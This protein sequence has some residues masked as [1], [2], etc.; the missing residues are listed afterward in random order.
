ML[1]ARPAC[2]TCPLSNKVGEERKDKGVHISE[3]PFSRGKH[4]NL[5][6]VQYRELLTK[7]ENGSLGY[8]TA[9]DKD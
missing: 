8:W 7:A 6:K 9:R 3:A 2:A 1:R 4:N 5:N